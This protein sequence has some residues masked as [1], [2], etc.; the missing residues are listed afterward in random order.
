LINAA[1][2]LYINTTADDFEEVW[3]NEGLSHIAEE[4]LFYESTKLQPRANINVAT[5][6]RSQ[7]TIDAFSNDLIAN[8]GRYESYLERPSDF[9]PFSSN[10]SLETRGATWSFLRYAADQRASSDGDIW[11]RLVNSSSTG[12][13]NLA[14]VFGADVLG[15]TRSWSVSVATDDLASVA[16]TY[17]QPSWNSRDIYAAL[18]SSTVFPLATRTLSSTAPTAITLVA[19][20]SAYLRFGVGAATSPTISWTTQNAAVQMT[21]VRTK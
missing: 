3:L 15:L 4:L 2:R 8:F 11:N 18:L 5:I 12:F 19:G 9:S 10:D 13:A 20:G 7:A 1:R 21:L 16:S 6:R 17:Q 14:Q